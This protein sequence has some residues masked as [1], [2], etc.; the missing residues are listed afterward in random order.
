MELRTHLLSAAALAG[1]LAL[2]PF[3][4]AGYYQT[5]PTPQDRAATQA[6]SEQSLERTRA[7]TSSD[8]AAK[9]KFDAEQA[10]VMRARARIA[11][12]R[13]SYNREMAA[14]RWDVFYGHERFRDVM[15][16]PSRRLVGLAVRTHGDNFVGRISDVDAVGAG[17]IAVSVRS[18]GTTWIDARDMRFDPDSGVVYTDLSRDQIGA[19]TNMRYPR[20]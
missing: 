16:V 7:A 3:A 9:A 10:A 20:F 1:A 2:T 18:G 11:A 19:M 17:R 4:L 12:E 14:R 15:S 6:T 5:N 8:A 13:A